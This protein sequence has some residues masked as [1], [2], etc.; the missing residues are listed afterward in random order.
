MRRLNNKE[1]PEK[2]VKK[3]EIK[4]ASKTQE[5]KKVEEETEDVPV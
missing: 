4:G 5:V 3:R 1:L 2:S